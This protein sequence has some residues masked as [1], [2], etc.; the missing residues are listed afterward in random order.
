MSFPYIL[1]VSR[2]ED[3]PAFKSEWFINVLKDGYVNMCSSYRDYRISFDNVKFIVFWTKNPRPMIPYLD[4]IKLDYYFQ[5]TLNFYPEYE[6]N[7]PPIA[8][9]VRTFIN[10]SKKIGKEKVI[11][12]FDPII[13]NDIISVDN[14]LERINK[15]GR[16]VSP[17]TEKLVFSFIDP[18][19]KLNDRFR[20]L[21]E[22]EMIDVVQGIKEMNK[23]WGLK[24]ATCAERSE[25]EGI[26][27]NKCIDPDLIKR[28]SGDPDWLKER[29]DK[30]QRA[31]CGCIESSDIGSFKSCQ[32]QCDYCY[33][34]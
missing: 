14:V 34:Q 11:W 20:D 30:N 16:L 26:E 10:L 29:K 21:T 32:H 18:Y 7:V 24:L 23:S 5:Y 1:S 3:V 28:I 22:K 15:I 6:K 9:R 19:F 2:R 8:E 31:F 12:R 13:I 33:G 4:D 25:F 17:Y 27:H